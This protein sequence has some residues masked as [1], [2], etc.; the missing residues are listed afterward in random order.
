MKSDGLK[1][2]QELLDHTT[3]TMT[4]RYAHLSQEHKRNAIKLINGF[5]G[6]PVGTK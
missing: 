3:L 1:D 2:V 4:L 6:N 5:T